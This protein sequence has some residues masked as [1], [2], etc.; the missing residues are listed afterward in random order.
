[1]NLSTG[2]VLLEYFF[3]FFFTKL[4]PRT[5]ELQK[6][7]LQVLMLMG[8]G[9][10][11]HKWKLLKPMQQCWVSEALPLTPLNAFFPSFS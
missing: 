11:E 5:D 2:I 6:Q 3:F 9:I 4:C 10:C 8:K 1:M 7:S